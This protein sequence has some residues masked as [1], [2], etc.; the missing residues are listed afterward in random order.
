MFRKV[1]KVNKEGT[2]AVS[3]PSEYVEKLRIQK[4]DMV[5][6]ELVGKTLRIKKVVML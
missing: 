5:N 4:G 2:L 6:I 3:L 1:F